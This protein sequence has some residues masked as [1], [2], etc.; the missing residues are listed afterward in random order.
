MAVKHTYKIIGQIQVDENLTRGRAIRLHCIDC[1][2]GSLG[3]VRQCQIQT[4]P[5][6]PFRMGRNPEK[7][8][9]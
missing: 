4:C 2:G 6:W 1:S 5:L 9:A 8:G 3:E 7:Q